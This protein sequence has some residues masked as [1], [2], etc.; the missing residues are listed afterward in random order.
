VLIYET[1]QH[2]KTENLYAVIVI[3]ILCQHNLA[4]CTTSQ[5]ACLAHL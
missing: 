1:V 5:T 2:F 3:F 4:L